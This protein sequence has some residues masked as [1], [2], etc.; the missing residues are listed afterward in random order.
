MQNPL[1]LHGEIE[2]T[3]SGR[4]KCLVVVSVPSY[5]GRVLFTPGHTD[6]HMALM[7]EE[8]QAVFSGACILG[9]GTAVFEDLYDYMKSLQVLLNSR[10][11]LIYPGL[12][13]SL[14]FAY[15]NLHDV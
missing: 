14:I 10:A 5:P 9:E 4:F 12:H 15:V 3:M 6:D 1:R 13:S 8:E 2:T 7:L 11:D